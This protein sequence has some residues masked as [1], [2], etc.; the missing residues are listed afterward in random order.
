LKVMTGLVDEAKTNV[1]LIVDE[2]QQ[3]IPNEEGNRLLLAFKFARD[4]VNLRA[5]IANTDGDAK[6]LFSADAASEYSKA[7]GR[8]VKIEEIQSIV[9]ELMA[10]N[11]AMRRGH[12]LYGISDPF[13]QEVWRERQTFLF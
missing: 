3:S 12:G 6:G 8:E 7:I 1:V 5:R 9:N 13:V 11:I 10:A 4:A 2:F